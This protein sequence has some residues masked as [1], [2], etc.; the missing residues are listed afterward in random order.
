MANKP[1]VRAIFDNVHTLTT[2]IITSSQPFKALL[3]DEV[4]RR[5]EEAHKAKKLFATIFEINTTNVY[6]ELHKRNWVQALEACLL[7]YVED[8]DYTT[9]TR[10]KGL[11]KS[12]KNKEHKP[13]IKAN[14]DGE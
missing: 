3:K 10:I 11:I 6:I 14:T 7:W 1:P 5:V 12:I 2:E 4:P 8:E 9:C 13:S